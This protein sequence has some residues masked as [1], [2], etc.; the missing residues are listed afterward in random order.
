M[1]SFGRLSHRILSPGYGRFQRGANLTPRQAGRAGPVFLPRSVLVPGA[2]LT[3]LVVTSRVST[4]AATSRVPP[5]R[6]HRRTGALLT[7]AA[8]SR[9]STPARFLS[10]RSAECFADRSPI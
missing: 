3:A 10:I 8:T 2:L 5:R 7:A 6:P 4:P 9:V 1:C